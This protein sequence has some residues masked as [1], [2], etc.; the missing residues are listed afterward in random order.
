M[1]VIDMICDFPQVSA[2]AHPSLV[3]T[4]RGWR[5][6]FYS[7]VG[8]RGHVQKHPY[9]LCVIIWLYVYRCIEI[10]EQNC[11]CIHACMNLSCRKLDR[12]RWS[13]AGRDWACTTD[14]PTPD[15]PGPEDCKKSFWV[16]LLATSADYVR[17]MKHNSICIT[18][19]F[20]DFLSIPKQSSRM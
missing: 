16:E 1:M 20:R 5:V 12:W 14:I 13:V 7:K 15:S 19:T 8:G 18:A 3:Y 4:C 2:H 6:G 10:Y 11:F 9:V 17:V